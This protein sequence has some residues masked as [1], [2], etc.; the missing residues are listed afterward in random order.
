M[1]AFINPSIG[2][3]RLQ[4]PDI[5]DMDPTRDPYLLPGR[6]LSQAYITGGGSNL[7]NVASQGARQ[8]V[9]IF[10]HPKSSTLWLP[11]KTP[12]KPFTQTTVIHSKR[13]LRAR[14][15]QAQTSLAWQ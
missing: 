2:P 14:L 11:P 6:I 1:A 13:V 5:A 9:D 3:Y 4:T 15:F 12:Y 8:F 10:V 7:P